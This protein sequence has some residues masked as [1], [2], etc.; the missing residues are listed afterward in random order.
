MFVASAV[1]LIAFVLVESRVKAPLL[2]LRVVTDRNRGGV[3]L[4]LGLAIVAI[5]V[6]SCS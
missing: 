3:Y 1:L 5:S 2:P 4:S 6:C